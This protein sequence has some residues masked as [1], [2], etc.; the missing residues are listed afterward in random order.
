MK[1]EKAQSMRNS[2][3]EMSDRGGDI[4]IP[5][6]GSSQHDL[7]LHKKAGL[8]KTLRIVSCHVQRVLG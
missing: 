5:V 7:T 8:R 6:E 1:D 4:Y 2:P 3:R